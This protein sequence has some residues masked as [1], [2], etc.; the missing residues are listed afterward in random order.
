MPRDLYR[1]VPSRGYH[2]AGGARAGTSQQHRST[3]LY[4][5]AHHG[6]MALRQ[7]VYGNHHYDRGRR[8]GH[9]IALIP[10][11]AEAE[12]G[13]PTDDMRAPMTGQQGRVLDPRELMMDAPE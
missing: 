8:E 13:P 6:D 9:I 11:A 10:D 7:P 12:A 4:K 5:G 1:V 2:R 3:R